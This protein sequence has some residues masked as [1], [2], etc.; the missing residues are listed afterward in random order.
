MKKKLLCTLIAAFFLLSLVGCN[1]S[2]G[3]GT[4]TGPGGQTT[5][6]VSAEARHI[7]IG[8][9]YDQFY[10]SQH[11]DP[12]ENPRVTNPFLAQMQ[13]DNMRRIETDYD[14]TLEFV[15]L[16][17]NGVQESITTSIMA[18]MPD[19]DIYQADTQFGIPAV[20][21]G[22]AISLDAMM[23]DATPEMARSFEDVFGDNDVMNNYNLAQDETFLFGS[24]ISSGLPIYPL[25][26]N[27]TMI[28]GLN[29]D[30]PQDLWDAGE[31]TWAAWREYLIAITDTNANIY[32][33]SGYWTNMLENL[34][35][36]NG[37]TIASGPRTTIEDSATIE[38]L[39][40]IYTIYNVDR[41]AR[42]WVQ[43]NWEVNNNLYAQGLSGFFIGADWL[44]SE[45]GGGDLPFKIG[46]VPWPV[47]PSGSKE[48]NLH[49]ATKGNWFFIPRGTENPALV[50]HVFFEWTNWY[51]WDREI[52]VDM[53]WS[54][55][56]YM[57]ERNFELAFFM[58][59]NTGFDIWGDLGVGD[60]LSM[61]P[62]MSGEYTGAQYAR[63]VSQVIQDALDNFFG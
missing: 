27:L 46:V 55:N 36:S 4:G 54:Q 53:E 29:L 52:A 32:G 3:G 44:F 45:Q 62:I 19:V 39:E 11:F 6:N 15:N 2:D 33:W 61:V 24:S 8:T 7:T 30:N 49:G 48:T 17:W 43:E 14:I 25:A 40:L 22:F 58:S 10:T 31:W 41:T 63:S 60:D 59:Q 47:G 21:S 16:T 50:F 13:I 26:F 35:F 42:P 5:P 20:L 23:L 57:T 51:G 34:L 37:T 9:W 56:N 1:D 38:V 28:E 12:F 18:G